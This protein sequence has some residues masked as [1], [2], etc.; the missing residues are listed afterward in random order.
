MDD[1]LLGAE[2]ILLKALRE[3]DHSAFTALY[4]KYWQDMYRVAYRKLGNRQHAE[5]IVQDIFTRLW[6]DRASLKID[7]LDRYLFSAVRY[8]VID[9]LRT[10]LPTQEYQE[11]LDQLQE[12]QDTGTEGTILMND[13]LDIIDAGLMVLPDKTREVFKLYRFENWSVKK[14]ADHFQISE[15]TIEYHLSRAHKYIKAYLTDILVLF[16]ACYLNHH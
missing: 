13:L 10:A 7:Y 8:E 12:I 14:I 15:R 2:Q 11:A 3:G 4:K 5:E 9:H 1:K 6:K 16:L